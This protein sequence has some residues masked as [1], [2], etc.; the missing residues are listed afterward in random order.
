MREND[1]FDKLMRERFQS[2]AYDF[3]E[4]HWQAAEKLILE[5]EKKDKRKKI[6]GLM[7][8]LIFFLVIGCWLFLIIPVAT[9]QEKS[10]VGERKKKRKQW[11]NH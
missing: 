11:L 9:Q 5:K 1:Q 3:D 4:K 10:P 8:S 6:F 2:E 7:L